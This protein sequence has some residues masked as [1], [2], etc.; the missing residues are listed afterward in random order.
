[1]IDDATTQDQPTTEEATVTSEPVRETQE[2]VEDQQAE[3]AVTQAATTLEQRLDATIAERDKCVCLLVALA[4]DC[5]YYA[6][7]GLDQ[8]TDKRFAAMDL[9]SGQVWWYLQDSEITALQG[10]R[11]YDKPLEAITDDVK[12]QRVLAAL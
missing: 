1:M 9:P 3:E 11:L 6:G 10:V 7:V 8:A 4:I 12:Y 2:Q 5:D